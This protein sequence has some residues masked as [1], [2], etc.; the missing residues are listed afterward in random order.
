MKE[1]LSTQMLTKGGNI[2][3]KYKQ[4]INETSKK[5]DIE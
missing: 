2:S 5:L 1:I 4:I 3:T